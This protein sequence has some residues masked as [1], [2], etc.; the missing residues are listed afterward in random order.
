MEKSTISNKRILLELISE[1]GMNLQ[2]ASSILKKDREVVLA[3]VIK[4]GAALQFADKTL[5]SD[6]QIVVAALENDAEASIAYVD[7]RLLKDQQFIL[8][9]LCGDFWSYMHENNNYKTYFNTKTT[10]ELLL[11]EYP[12][13]Y[14]EM[15]DEF[16]NN[17]A[18]FVSCLKKFDEK[19]DY[20]EEFLEDYGS[21]FS[22]DEEVMKACYQLFPKKTFAMLSVR[23]KQAE[24]YILELLSLHVDKGIFDLLPKEMKMKN[25][26]LLS[27]VHENIKVF[28]FIDSEYHKD[29][30]FLKQC[31]YKNPSLIV[32]FNEKEILFYYTELR[33]EVLDLSLALYI[34]SVDGMLLEEL[35]EFNSDMEVV[36]KALQNNGLALEFVA[37]NLRRNPDVIRWAMKENP[38]ALWKADESMHSHP[39]FT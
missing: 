7:K 1:D 13:F 20:G 17:A 34:V 33:M 31:L 16:M 32:Y 18:L 35:Q 26:F 25:E 2:Q 21:R 37:E 6:I 12:D 8:D 23:L 28:Y 14:G 27:A 22:D 11:S 10:I 38:Q 39:D 4:Q 15:D 30:V 5:Q 9:N 3:A 36:Y 29:A 19:Y 24:A